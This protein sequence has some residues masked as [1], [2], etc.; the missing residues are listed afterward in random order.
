MSNL[1]ILSYV[2]AGMPVYSSEGRH[3]GI[4][5]RVYEHRPDI[6][7]EMVT[8]PVWWKPRRFQNTRRYLPGIAVARVFD[9][10]VFLSKSAKTANGWTWRPR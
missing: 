4:V 6:Y 10:C 7:I 3:L 8:E 2:C 1:A 9:R 5:A